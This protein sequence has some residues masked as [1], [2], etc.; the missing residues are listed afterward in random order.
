MTTFVDVPNMVRWISDR[1]VANIIGGMAEY[2][3]AD[4]TRWEHFDKTPRV[5]SHTPSA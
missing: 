4:F 5:A 2:I 3:R 1:G